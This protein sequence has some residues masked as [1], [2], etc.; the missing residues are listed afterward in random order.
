MVKWCILYIFCL[1]FAGGK[2]Q[3]MPGDVRRFHKCAVFTFACTFLIFAPPLKN[4]QRRCRLGHR[5]RFKRWGR[6]FPRPK[7]THPSTHFCQRH[8]PTT[9]PGFNPPTHRPKKHR[10]PLK[11]FFPARRSAS[12]TDSWRTTRRGGGVSSGP[13]HTISTKP[14]PSTPQKGV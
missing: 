9:P 10:K 12:R 13:I 2:S 7:P 8:P 3:I 4:T 6:H 11:H 1:P 14:N 5:D